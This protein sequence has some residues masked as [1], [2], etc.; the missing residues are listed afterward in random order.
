MGRPRP[1]VIQPNPLHRWLVE[2]V[3][4][5]LADLRISQAELSRRTDLSQKHVSDMLIGK[6]KGSIPTWDY[7]LL[8]VESRWAIPDLRLQRDQQFRTLVQTWTQLPTEDRGLLLA[9]AQRFLDDVKMEGR[10]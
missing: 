8:H 7:L 3:R 2:T 5:G 1:L 6:E 4:D 10:L 9:A